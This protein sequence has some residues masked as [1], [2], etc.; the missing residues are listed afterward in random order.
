MTSALTVSQHHLPLPPY[1]G[2]SVGHQSVKIYF[3]SLGLIASRHT[4][5][6]KV[7]VPTAN[8]VSVALTLFVTMVPRKEQDREGTHTSAGPAVGAAGLRQPH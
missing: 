2:P 3:E 7:W 1:K 8:V 6:K 5:R 4:G